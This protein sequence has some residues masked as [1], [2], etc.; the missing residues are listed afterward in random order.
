[1][2]FNLKIMMEQLLV[3][4]FIIMAILLLFQKIQQENQMKHLRMNLLDGIRKLN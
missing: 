4:M 1:M 2:L 3:L